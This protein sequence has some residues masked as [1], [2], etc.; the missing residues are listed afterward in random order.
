M[1]IQEKHA[2]EREEPSSRMP[3]ARA[4]VL[5]FESF[6]NSPQGQRPGG[7]SDQDGE[8]SSL[9]LRLFGGT[10]LSIAA[11]VVITLTQQFSSILTE[12]RQDLNRM[13]ESRGDLARKE[14]V[15]AALKD[16]QAAASGIAALRERSLLL[17]QQLRAAEE[18][19]KQLARDLRE[20]RERLAV[21]AGRQN[22]LRFVEAGGEPCD[23][24]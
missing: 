18:D 22:A 3:G 13:H 2:P 7:K 10:L 21:S 5:A 11:L 23:S 20:L 4:A 16:L 1:V 24:R 19:R 15:A 17:E 9:F 8:R 6:R 14:E 12:V